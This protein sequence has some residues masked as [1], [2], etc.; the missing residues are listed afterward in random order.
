[1][2]IFLIFPPRS[3][4]LFS[5][6]HHNESFNIHVFPNFHLFLFSNCLQQVNGGDNFS[7]PPS[8]DMKAFKAD[9]LKEMRSEITKAKN[10]IIDG[11]YQD[12]KVNYI[13]VISCDVTFL[14]H[15]NDSTKKIFCLFLETH[16]PMISVFD[17]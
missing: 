8:F 5:F 6:T 3:S 15:K 17:E 11:E 14:T 2:E 7:L 9:I 16:F 4:A 12:Y 10:E 1:M 13:H